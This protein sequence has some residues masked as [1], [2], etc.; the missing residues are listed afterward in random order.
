MFGFLISRMSSCNSECTRKTFVSRT[1]PGPAGEAQ[2]TLPDLPDLKGNLW[3]GNAYK[4]KEA[5]K[6]GR[7]RKDGKSEVQGGKKKS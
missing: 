4:G 5:K 1:L 3:A 6:A 7:K 2:S